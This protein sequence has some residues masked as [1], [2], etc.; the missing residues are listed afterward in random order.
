MICSQTLLTIHIGLEEAMLTLNARI[1]TSRY[2]NPRQL[3]Y[4]WGSNPSVSWDWWIDPGSSTYL[5]REEFKHMNIMRDNI[6]WHYWEAWEARWPIVYPAPDYLDRMTHFERIQERAY[7][8]M[9]KK[10]IKAARAQGLKKRD[11][12]PGAWPS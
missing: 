11:R 3:I 8:R 9:N 2:E 6:S 1:D 5:V 10:S 12:M 4:H 7:R